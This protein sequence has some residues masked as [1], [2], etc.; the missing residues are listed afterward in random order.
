MCAKSMK[1]FESDFSIFFI[2]K[3]KSP[4]DWESINQSTVAILYYFFK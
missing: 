4:V 1:G 2:C 3:T